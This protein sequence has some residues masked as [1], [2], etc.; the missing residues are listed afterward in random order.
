MNTEFVGFVMRPNVLP[1]KVDDDVVI[2]EVVF[3]VELVTVEI[4]ES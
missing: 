4:V 2:V 3:V 1:N